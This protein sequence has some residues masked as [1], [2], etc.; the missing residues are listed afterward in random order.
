MNNIGPR[1]LDHLLNTAELSRNLE[2]FRRLSSEQGLEITHG[3]RI[4]PRYAANLLQMRIRDLAAANQSN[5][6]PFFSHSTD[7]FKTPCVEGKNV[8]SGR[9]HFSIE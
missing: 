8:A 7:Q 4:R 2:P 3:N 9:I 1:L 6:D 5:F